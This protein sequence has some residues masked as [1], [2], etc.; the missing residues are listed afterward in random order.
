MTIWAEKVV[1]LSLLILIVLA[2]GV[3]LSL[4][5]RRLSFSI[6]AIWIYIVWDIQLI[7]MLIYPSLSND[8]SM[9]I[10]EQMPDILIFIPISMI[11]PFVYSIGIFWF[12]FEVQNAARVFFELS[13]TFILAILL[14]H[15]A[16]W[17]RSSRQ[18]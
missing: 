11:M 17:I 1:A 13:G 2:A 14:V 3:L 8:N 5:R 10:A 12:I 15:L 16:L 6:R 4:L 9:P 18:A 7:I